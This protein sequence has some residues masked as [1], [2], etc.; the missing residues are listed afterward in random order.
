[1]DGKAVDKKLRVGKDTVKLPLENNEEMFSRLKD[2][3]VKIGVASE[4]LVV[5]HYVHEC[6]GNILEASGVQLQP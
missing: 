3:G 4:A 2:L 1:M 5:C 6:F